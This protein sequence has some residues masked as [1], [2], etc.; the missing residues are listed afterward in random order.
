MLLVKLL[1]LLDLEKIM[2]VSFICELYK[3]SEHFKIEVCAWVNNTLNTL[4]IEELVNHY[5]I[6]FMLVFECWYPCSSW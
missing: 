6:S 4:G 1:A 2:H 3:I 5:I